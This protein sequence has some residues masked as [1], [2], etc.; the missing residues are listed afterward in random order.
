MPNSTT[1]SS[2]LGWFLPGHACHQKT[3]IHRWAKFFFFLKMGSRGRIPCTSYLSWYSVRTDWYLRPLKNH[4]GYCEHNFKLLLPEIT[5]KQKR[6]QDCTWYSVLWEWSV[7]PGSQACCKLCEPLASIIITIRSNFPQHFSS[8]E[9]FLSKWAF[10]ERH[11]K[12]PQDRWVENIDLGSFCHRSGK[13]EV[14]G[15]V[16]GSFQGWGSTLHPG[17]LQLRLSIS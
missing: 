9:N 2:G 4:C 13:A 12:C 14:M 5:A 16:M 7:G 10:W 15:R 1:V 17:S 6:K 11:S 3:F 8:K